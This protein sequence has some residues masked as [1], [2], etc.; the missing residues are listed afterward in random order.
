MI[1]HI[2]APSNKLSYQPVEK[3]EAKKAYHLIL[4][5]LR[6]KLG[7]LGYM[8]IA[9]YILILSGNSACGFWKHD[10]KGQCRNLASLAH[11]D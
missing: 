5:V 9:R 10:L 4:A 8:L 11:G 7:L 3:L 2:A 1:Q 6:C